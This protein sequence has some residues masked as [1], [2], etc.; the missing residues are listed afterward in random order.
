MALDKL[1][2]STQLDSDLTSVANAIRAKSSGSSQLA[3]PAGFVSAIA[4]IPSGGGGLTLLGSGSYTYSG[5]AAP[6]ITFPVSYTGT[7]KVLLVLKDQTDA[8]LGETIGALAILSTGVSTIDAAFE[9]G[10]RAYKIKSTADAVSYVGAQPGNTSACWLCTSNGTYSATGE[11]I[12][13]NRY[14][15]ANLMQPGSY[16]YYI[17]G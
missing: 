6:N 12:R 15:N 13:V 5:N 16:S 14:G 1:V 7:P 9:Y 2:D 17:Y 3:F 4:A 8:G 10:A 11:Y